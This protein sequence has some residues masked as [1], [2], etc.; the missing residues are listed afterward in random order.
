[1]VRKAKRDDKHLKGGGGMK[2]EEGRNRAGRK[3]GV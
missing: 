2:S 1:V 3:E